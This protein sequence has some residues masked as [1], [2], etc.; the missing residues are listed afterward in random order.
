[1][2]YIAQHIPEIT[3]IPEDATYLLWMS[4]EK[5]INQGT[6]FAAFLRENTGLYLSD[7]EQYGKAGI[8]FVRMNIACLRSVLKD[9]L[10]RLEKGV[11]LY[12]NR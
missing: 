6:V 5:M 12:Q 11:R 8:G 7:G 10:E 1:L 2:K 4:T 3:S 9:G